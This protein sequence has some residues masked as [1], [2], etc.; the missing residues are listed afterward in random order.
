MPTGKNTPFNLTLL[1][2]LL[3][4]TLFVKH[5]ES[6]GA[7][8]F[9]K[10]VNFFTCHFVHANLFHWFCNAFALWVMRPSPL[11]I[12]IPLVYAAAS[13]LFTLEP[14]IGFSAVLYAYIGMNII[15]WKVSLID[16]ATFIIAN[17]ITAFIPG[18]AFGV[19]LAAFLFGIAHGVIEYQLNRIVLKF[20]GK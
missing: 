2:L 6:H 15:K 17:A 16:W 10:E 19:H 14:T 5:P 11:M 7:W 8:L 4:L 13:M 12:A 1:G 18:I 3:A 9:A 20:E